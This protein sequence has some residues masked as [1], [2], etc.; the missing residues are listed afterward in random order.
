LNCVYREIF[1]TK[2][3]LQEFD[4][5]MAYFRTVQ[6]QRFAWKNLGPR[7]ADAFVSSRSPGSQANP[8][9]GTAAPTPIDERR[10]KAA[11][12]TERRVEATMSSLR[13]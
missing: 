10:G 9:T 11:T 2:E 6:E 12:A 4:G 1:P 8:F 3:Q 13:I 5:I 7:F